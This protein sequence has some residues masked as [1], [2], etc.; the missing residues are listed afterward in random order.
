MLD[1]GKSLPGSQSWDKECALETDFQGALDNLSTQAGRAQARELS[2][3]K[4]SE[5]TPEEKVRLLAA[6]QRRKPDPT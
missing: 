3:R 1:Q 4:P 5:L 6:L 2:G